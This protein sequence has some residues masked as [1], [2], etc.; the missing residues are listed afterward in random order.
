MTDDRNITLLP[1]E[2]CRAT[3]T[4]FRESERGRAAPHICIRCWGIGLRGVRW[5]LSPHEDAGLHL[6]LLAQTAGLSEALCR[7]TAA[8]PQID[9]D[10]VEETRCPRC[11]VQLGEAL[12]A[13]HGGRDRWVWTG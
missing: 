1:C 4:V 3:G 13:V 11:Q 10:V 7:L 6:F 8:T 12:T 2:T 5:G 9:W